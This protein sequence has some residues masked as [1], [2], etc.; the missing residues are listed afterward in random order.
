M[1]YKI[2]IQSNVENERNAKY[3]NSNPVRRCC[4]GFQYTEVKHMF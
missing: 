2:P 1:N 4:M 3:G